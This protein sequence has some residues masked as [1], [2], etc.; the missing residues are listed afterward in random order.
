MKIKDLP[1]YI[2]K[3]CQEDLPEIPIDAL[4]RALGPKNKAYL[5]MVS[6]PGQISEEKA[7]EL[8]CIFR[9]AL[10]TGDFSEIKERERRERPSV[11]RRAQ[12]N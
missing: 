5:A 11:L 2:E 10:I 9:C 6:Y 4:K 7:E 3:R 1:D 12:S 8:W